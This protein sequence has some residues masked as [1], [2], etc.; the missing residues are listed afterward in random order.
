MSENHPGKLKGPLKGVRVLDLTSVMMGPYATQIFADLGADVIKV[1]SPTGDTTRHL[2]PG[3]E[4]NRGAMFMNL[5]RGKRS[6]ALD[7][8]VAEARQALLTLCETADVFIHSMRGG[9][10]KR[11]GLDYAAVSTANPR[12]IYANLWGYGRN[13]RY[14][15]QPAYDDIVQARSGI[16]DLQGRHGGSE[17]RYLANI[18]ADKVAGLT[19]AYAVMAA[20]YAREKTGEG[21]EVEVPM[22]ETLT[23]FVC[24]EHLMGA[25]FDP[26][27]GPTGYGRVLSPERRPYRTSDGHIAV[28]VYTDR[29]WQNFFAAIGNPDWSQKDIF[30]SL[31]TR[32][33]NV[34][35]VLGHLGDTL[36]TRTT[37]EWLGVFEQAQLPA[38]PVNS[39]DDVIADPHM[40]DVG[41]WQ[42]RDTPD[43]RVRMSG[44]PTSFSA[45]PGAVGDPG[46]KLGAHGRDVL[47]EAGL[48]DSD[49][50][51]LV[52][53]GA[54]GGD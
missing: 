30:R 28:M 33:E 52:E 13:G 32:T 39:L 26:P 47:A 38:G 43:G 27:L 17:P 1:E 14:A 24:V 35:E 29:Q 5:N 20:L 10:M 22:F 40:A 3:P 19:G 46:P 11:L 4:D 53:S 50:A 42:K 44:L 36:K 9:A 6:I 12:I 25:M 16:V 18:V 51:A 23:S 49:I 8:K 21:Q 37:A 45:T 31:R 15:D 7:L 41:Y 34:T 54:L 2:P 48:S